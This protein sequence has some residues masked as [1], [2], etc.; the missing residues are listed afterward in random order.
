M[1]FRA[2][3][4]TGIRVSAVSFGAGPV[5]SLM[6]AANDGRQQ[7]QTVEAALALGINWFDTAATYG[8]G[9]SERSLGTAFQALNVGEG[10][11][12]ATKVRIAG[13][14]WPRLGTFIRESLQGSLARLGLPRVTLLQLHNSVT[15]NRGDLPTSV[16]PRDVLGPGGILEVFEELQRAGLVQ[17]LGLTAL[18]NPVSLAELLATDR[19]A[20]IQLPYNMIN[21]TAGV[22]APSG[23]DETDHGN[24][25]EV[26]HAR[27]I[28]V[29][30]IRV[31]AG[32]ALAGQLPSEHTRKTPFFPLA[33]YERD[34]RRAA[35]LEKSLPSGVA[36]PEAAVRFVLG[37]RR[38]ASALIGFSNPGQVREVLRYAAAGP[39]P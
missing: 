12:V 18:G 31:F 24:L 33:L 37:D 19:F 15:S 11:H 38:V 39:L 34:L 30:A 23:W 6:T 32:G 8:D 29:F 13:D 10:V 35:T 4:A 27:N 3:G 28:G 26:C 17:H 14:A 22:P 1:E 9:Q 5:P 36:L 21:P 2:L 20:T 25:I 7:L 16:T